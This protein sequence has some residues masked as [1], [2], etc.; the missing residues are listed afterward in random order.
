MAGSSCDSVPREEE[1]PSLALA[2]ALQAEEDERLALE[3]MRE[4]EVAARPKQPQQPQQPAGQHLQ[5]QQQQPHQPGRLPGEILAGAAHKAVQH[6]GRGTAKKLEAHFLKGQ[7]ALSLAELLRIFRGD[8]REELLMLIDAGQRSR[9]EAEL[10]A[11]S[12]DFP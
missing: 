10:V 11:L 3:L 9:V 8:R 5:Q 7:M 2:L 4:D 6:L 1:D 12:L